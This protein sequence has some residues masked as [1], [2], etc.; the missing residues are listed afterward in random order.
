LALN[1][2]LFDV[3]PKEPG[4]RRRVRRDEEGAV[5]RRSHPPASANVPAVIDVTHA[6]TT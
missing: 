5:E 2:E 3:R 6:A 4:Q 1:A